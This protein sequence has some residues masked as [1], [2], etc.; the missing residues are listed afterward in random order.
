MV[1]SGSDD[2]SAARQG[3][4]TA[5]PAPVKALGSEAAPRLSLKRPASACSPESL[6]TSGPPRKRR[7]LS[8]SKVRG[9]ASPQLNGHSKC[10]LGGGSQLLLLPAGVFMQITDLLSVADLGRLDETCRPLQMS[11]ND[12][13]GPWQQKGNVAFQ[14]MELEV[15]GTF[16]TFEMEQP[17]QGLMPRNIKSRYRWFHGEVSTFSAPYMGD[18]IS[19]VKTA[20][21]VAYCKCRLRKDI[22]AEVPRSSVFLEVDVL[23]NADN[24]SLAIVD[25]EGGGK[26]SVTFSPETGAVLIEHKVQEDPRVIE[27]MYIHLLEQAPTGSKFEGSIGLLLHDGHLAFYRRWQ[28]ARTQ[29]REG[30]EKQQQWET[31]GFCTDLAWAV[32]TQLSLCLAFRDAGD[33]HVR[34]KKVANSPPFWPPKSQEA[35]Q[36]KNWTTLFGDESHPLAI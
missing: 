35:Y 23:A 36:P 33:Y 9:A 26:S 8:L 29:A 14:G 18:Q 5:T 34:I 7:P 1:S 11:N 22:L 4:A 24:L 13:L 28:N 25:F 10:S 15:A 19:S 3:S 2:A 20:D 6:A 30:E 32:G 31:T 17:F 21:E 12:R 16:L 27:G